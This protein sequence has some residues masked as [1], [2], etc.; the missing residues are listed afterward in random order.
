MVGFS[1]IALTSLFIVVDYRGK[2][3]HGWAGG[4]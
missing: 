1:F 4:C 2:E 3:M